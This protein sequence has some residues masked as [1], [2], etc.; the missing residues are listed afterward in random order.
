MPAST[1]PNFVAVKHEHVGGDDSEE[2]WALVA[3]SV[4]DPAAPSKGESSLP[5]MSLAVSQ[6]QG[7]RP[8]SGTTANKCK[9]AAATALRGSEGVQRGIL[10]QID[11]NHSCIQQGPVVVCPQPNMPEGRRV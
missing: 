2:G 9:V 3:L 4:G 6:Y 5:P 7:H 11:K 8:S 1:M 10:T